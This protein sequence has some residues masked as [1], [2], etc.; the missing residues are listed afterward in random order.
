MT[1]DTSKCIWIMASNL[2]DSAIEQFYFKKL[3]D[4]NDE[5]AGTVSIEPLKQEIER[6]LRESY[7]VSPST[8]EQ[9]YVRTD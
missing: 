2:G 1:V 7:S 5:E 3:A 8:N 4:R 9:I 6:E